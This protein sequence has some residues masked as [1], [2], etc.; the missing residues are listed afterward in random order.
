MEQ[1]RKSCL[2]FIQSGEQCKSIDINQT[3]DF[4]GYLPNH[5]RT[6]LFKEI[7]EFI[8]SIFQMFYNE[9]YIYLW[10]ICFYNVFL[11][12][13]ILAILILLL[14]LLRKNKHFS[15]MENN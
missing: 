8:T 11:I 3:S 12:F 10:M 13:I 15:N 5:M 4:G 2:Q 1:I 7:K 6:K 14:S 9:I